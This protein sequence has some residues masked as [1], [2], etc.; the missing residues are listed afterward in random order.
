MKKIKYLVFLF[1]FATIFLFGSNVKAEAA[2]YNITGLY[3][4]N[5][6]VDAGGKLYVDLNMVEKD[7]ST[8]IIGY[9]YSG[10]MDNHKLIGLTLKD[11]L[12]DNPY[13][14]LS[15]YMLPGESFHLDSLYV[16]DSKDSKSY[17]TSP[18]GYNDYMNLQGKDTFKVK[19]YTLSDF[20]TTGY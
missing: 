5:T 14:E 9:F 10:T 17:V 19:E 1:A 11:V 3:L 16:K 8:E 13:F 20:S 7:E 15:S 18:N 12:T 4:K 6:E 2:F